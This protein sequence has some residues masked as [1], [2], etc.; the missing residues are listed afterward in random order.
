MIKLNGIP[1]WKIMHAKGRKYNPYVQ[2]HTVYQNDVF[3][4][5]YSFM[6]HNGKM[7]EIQM[8]LSSSG[9]LS[10]NS[11]FGIPKKYTKSI[12]LKS[13]EVDEWERDRTQAFEKG[14]FR[15]EGSLINPNPAAILNFYKE[16][17]GKLIA[18]QITQLCNAE[19][20]YD[21]LSKLELALAFVQDIP[22]GIPKERPDVFRS[23]VI[24]PPE[25]LYQGF[26][27]CDSKCYLFASI[28]GNW[29]SAE[30]MALAISPGHMTFL[31]HHPGITEGKY[32]NPGKKNSISRR[33]QVQ[34]N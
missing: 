7:N 19:G 17:E 24:A 6:D 14:L 10:S 27:D 16:R 26:G 2:Y 1:N 9:L 12:R 22:Y 29:I 15:L 34:L 28:I 3:Q 20:K 32:L 25:I 33:L 18:Q 8:A 5:S 23:G 31:I 4:I 30:N 11:Q 13:H 21:S